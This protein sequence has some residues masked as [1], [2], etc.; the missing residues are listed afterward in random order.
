MY[1]LFIRLVKRFVRFY[2]AFVGDWDGARYRDL[3]GSGGMGPLLALAGYRS[4]S[5]G[6]LRSGE[7][8]PVR[9]PG[10]RP[11]VGEGL[12]QDGDQADAQNSLRLA[13]EGFHPDLNLLGRLYGQSSRE[14]PRRG[15]AVAVILLAEGL[16]E[17]RLSKKYDES[18]IGSRHQDDCE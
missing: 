5:R 7:P 12:G 6:A 9:E 17:S 10:C 16:L 11:E 4:D 18:R 3:K 13:E 14:Q 1:S 15:G 2:F 8:V